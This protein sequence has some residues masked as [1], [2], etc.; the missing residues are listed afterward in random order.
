M[1]PS[2]WISP[3]KSFTVAAC[4]LILVGVYVT[5][6]ALHFTRDL[7]WVTH[8]YQVITKLEKLDALEHQAVTQQRTYLITG[9]RSYAD[10]FWQSG[11]QARVEAAALKDMVSDNSGQEL[12]A[13]GLEALLSQRLTILAEV[14]GTYQA[15]GL[16]AA[17][18]K[19]TGGEGLK[20]QQ[21]FEARGAV[22]RAAEHSL[23]DQ[24]TE[25]M[26]RSL[27]W[28][29]A[30]AAL[31]IA[32]SL[33][34]LLAAYRLLAR[35]DRE[36]V[37]AERRVTEANRELGQSVS[38]L[39][40]LSG[41]MEELGKYA[42]M[43]QSA[44]GISEA[45]EI[46]RQSLQS[47]LPGLAGAV[48][49][50]R[51]SKDHADRIAA[52]GDPVLVSEPM[53]APGDC[54]CLRR[55]QVYTLDDVRAGVRCVHVAAPQGD[56]PATYACVPLAA[57][58]ETLGWLHLSAPGL[59]PLPKLSFAVSASEQLS[60]ALANLRLREA[61]R[62]QAIRDPLTGLFNRRYLEESL[63]REFNRCLRR[64]LP[65][66][67]LMLDI[68]H[69]KAFNDANGHPG[70]DALLAAFGGLLQ[71]H[72]RAEDIACRYGGEEF[73]LILPEASAEVARAKAEEIRAAAADLVVQLRG[74]D[75]PKVTVSL[76]LATFP[77][78]GH[79]ATVLLGSADKAL[80]EAKT[81]G[82]NRVATAPV[83][84]A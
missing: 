23:L 49:Y 13:A 34:I 27:G 77:D 24:R 47:L 83:I 28:L 36:R 46:T 25:S 81:G 72:S 29:L 32:A 60:L 52:W 1:K 39:E 78:H 2:A 54:W 31:G 65:L 55:N 80:Y 10:A 30:T 44:V 16:T 51:A 58:G 19:I 11:A 66:S 79:E 40:Q 3:A 15:Q 82:R 53:P 59:G 35:E 5:L 84:P 70:G 50:L 9:T 38:R 69:F 61:L 22:I 17:Q 14:L 12:Q 68:D 20:A 41:D 75:L 21:E 42:G 8:S 26:R 45:M 76:G 33:L 18:A 48:Y 43:L 73:T 67:I 62:N 7:H 64:K 57:Q 63:K 71:A 56:A 6:S 74:R 4:I 37:L